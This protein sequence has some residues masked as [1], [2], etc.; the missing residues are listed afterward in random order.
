MKYDEEIKQRI[1]LGP[2]AWNVEYSGIIRKISKGRKW[3][4]CN[5]TVKSIIFCG[6]ETWN[7]TESDKRKIIAVEMDALRRSCR[8]SREGK[9]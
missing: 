3:R 7:M 5:T 9:V 6:A 8:V 2:K 1:G 4:I